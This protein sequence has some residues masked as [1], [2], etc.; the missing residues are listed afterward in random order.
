MSPRARVGALLVFAFG[1]V[2]MFPAGV[3]G[4]MNVV[5]TASPAHAA[6]DQPVEVLIRTF[7]PLAGSDLSLDVG[8]TRTPFPAPS[9]YWS[10]LYAFSD[11]Y[12][13]KVEARGPGGESVSVIVAR[14][15]SDA[16]L[17]RGIAR[18]SS[19]GRWRVQ[20]LNYSGD[21][22]G[23]WAEVD[24]QP[25]LAV[26]AA[27]AAP[28]GQ[29]SEQAAVAVSLLAGLAGLAFGFIA[30]RTRRAVKVDRS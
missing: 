7:L 4:A 8:A 28:N 11:D 19:A 6:V 25:A 20:L 14:D 5:V 18:L 22:P 26:P 29:W 10:L 3:K 16:S 9:G 27:S 13:F 30:G 15:P 24:V 1:A 17:Y 2:A 21:A 12:P 23:T